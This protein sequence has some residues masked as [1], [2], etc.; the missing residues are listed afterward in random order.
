MTGEAEAIGK[1]LDTKEGHRIGTLY[2]GYAAVGLGDDPKPPLAGAV[3]QLELC[4]FLQGK[5]VLAGFL[6]NRLG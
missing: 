5:L 2:R 6:S 3:N 4:A 1:A